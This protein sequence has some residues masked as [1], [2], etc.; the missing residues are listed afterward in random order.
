[1][2]RKIL[3]FIYN[4][5][6]KKFLILKTNPKIKPGPIRWD[7]VIGAVNSGEVL[8]TAACR[9]IK[10]ETNLSVKK[11]ISLN[12]GRQRFWNGEVCDESFYFALVDVGAIKLN[13]EHTKFR[14][15]NFKDFIYELNWPDNKSDLT[16]R[17]KIILDNLES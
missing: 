1:M 7:T 14:W 8:D 17:L 15:L 9:E 10:E 2:K 5:E 6:I 3:S 16:K 11:I 13:K 12:W 4:S